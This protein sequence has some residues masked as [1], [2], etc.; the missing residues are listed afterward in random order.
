MFKISA[1]IRAITLCLLSSI[2]VSA[3]GVGP[4]DNLET[5]MLIKPPDQLI[6]VTGY[7]GELNL[8]GGE[9]RRFQHFH[10]GDN[11]LESPLD[12][13][14]P[15][16]ISFNGCYF[17][18][19]V[20]FKKEGV[21]LIR[22]ARKR[23]FSQ[24]VYFQYT[25]Q[26]VPP[27][28][29][30]II[31]PTETAQKDVWSDAAEAYCENVTA[32]MISPPANIIYPV[33]YTGAIDLSGIVVK[34]AKGWFPKKYDIADLDYTLESDVDFNTPGS[35]IVKVTYMDEKG[36]EYWFCFTVAVAERAG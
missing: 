14:G 4:D 7:D 12:A 5:L 18:P 11:F 16:Y 8:S 27:G 3:T 29:Y 30:K 22:L 35:Y 26:V 2:I 23:L 32:I 15:R 31:V 24:T 13:F 36:K 34:P 21:Y 33:G 9:L 10:D 1:L 19:K 6:Y 28:M 17:H 25:V 20:N